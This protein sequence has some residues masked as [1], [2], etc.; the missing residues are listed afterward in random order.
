M[1]LSNNNLSNDQPKSLS[2]QFDKKSV[3]IK[4][5]SKL[6]FQI[7]LLIS[8]SAV[9]L[10]MQTK[11]EIAERHFAKT[12][13]DYLDEIP[14]IT[15]TVE[16]PILTP[17]K[18][19]FVKPIPPKVIEKVIEVVPDDTPDKKITKTEIPL[20]TNTNKAIPSK[21]EEKPIILRSLMG[22]EFVPI[23]PGCE[24]SITNEDK[25]NCMS[26]KIKKYIVRK[27]NTNKLDD[28]E[29][30]KS[31]KIIVQ[32][33]INSKGNVVNVI[34]KAPNKTLEN[35]AVRVVSKLPKMKPGRQGKKNIAVQY[36]IPITFKTDF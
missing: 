6:Y 32:F 25:R 29:T 21:K 19:P 7:G 10:I 14:I 30:I 16:E 22:V 24:S 15:F 27:F 11:F 34:A 17:K 20:D 9:Y 1:K 33:T 4:W 13:I 28:S 2:K 26:K 35:E 8:L 3:N 31:Q 12:D 18:K 23:F 36:T 5:N